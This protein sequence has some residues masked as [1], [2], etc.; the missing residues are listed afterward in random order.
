[1]GGCVQLAGVA[2]IVETVGRV[3]R[4]D[5]GE[6]QRSSENDVVVRRTGVLITRGMQLSLESTALHASQSSGKDNNHRFFCQNAWL[7][8]TSIRE[9]DKNHQDRLGPHTCISMAPA[10]NT[11]CRRSFLA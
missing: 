10:Q 9:H 1:M 11:H 8:T 6:Q 5:R 7:G 4:L 3:E 2:S